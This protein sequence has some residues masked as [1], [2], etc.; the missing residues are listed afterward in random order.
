MR[1]LAIFG[2]DSEDSHCQHFLSFLI[3]LNV[4]EPD[5]FTIMYVGYEK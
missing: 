2:A 3:A 1:M 4:N 5:L